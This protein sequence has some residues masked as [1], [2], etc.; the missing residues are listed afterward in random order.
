MATIKE[1]VAPTW[2]SIAGSQFLIAPLSHYD[3]IDY[4][5][6]ISVA[7]GKIKVSG[8]GVRIA[9]NGVRDWKQVTNAKGEDIPFNRE[10]YDALPIEVLVVIARKVFD[11]T[12]LSEIERKN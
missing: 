11:C 12:F 1:K 8:E 7:R 5:H 9:G 4:R 6:E 10:A 2:H 3:A